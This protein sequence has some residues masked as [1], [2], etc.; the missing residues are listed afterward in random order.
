MA[1]CICVIQNGER[2]AHGHCLAFHDMAAVG[3]VVD[4]QTLTVKRG[5]FFD[6]C[7]DV[8]PEEVAACMADDLE[9]PD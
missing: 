6:L 8:A 2:F 3:H 4:P 9:T 5:S 7:P 1:K